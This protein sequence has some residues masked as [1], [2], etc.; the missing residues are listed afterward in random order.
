MNRYLI[1]SQALATAGDLLWARPMSATSALGI[2][3]RSLAALNERCARG[4]PS[5]C[6]SAR[7]LGNIAATI[8]TRK[9]DP[10]PNQAADILARAAE[11]ATNQRVVGEE[12]AAA[13]TSSAQPFQEEGG[14]EFADSLLSD[15][16]YE[17]Q[18]RHEVVDEG[19]DYSGDE[20]DEFEAIKPGNE[21]QDTYGGGEY[22][23]GVAVLEWDNH[24]TYHP[25]E[26]VY[27]GQKHW[28]ALRQ[29]DP[30]ALPTFM[31]GDVPGKSDAWR[32]VSP[33]EV[34][35]GNVAGDVLGMFDIGSAQLRMNAL[36]PVTV[37]IAKSL[38]HG[39]QQVMAVANTTAAQHG[40][41]GQTARDGVVGH[42]Q[43]HANKLAGLKNGQA[44]YASGDDVKLYAMRAWIEANAVEEG[45]AYLDEA[46]T[47]MWAEIG[48]ELAALP[49]EI[50]QAARNLPGQIFE[51]ATGIP[52]WAF[53]LGAAVIVGG[54]VYG[55]FKILSGPAG[56]AVVGHYLRRR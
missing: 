30:P 51:G 56:G 35:A 37:G 50:L 28:R 13:A 36:K 10:L 40:L 24:N 39:G 46:W 38:V 48:A 34:Y 43:W 55:I 16:G 18:A 12:E 54:L 42:L 14:D 8:H 44:L 45:A 29:V 15:F 21:E 26:I 6:E 11:D 33:A 1:G 2:V 27:C 5:A 23:V 47:A 41:P 9:I 32:E 19:N 3:T 20:E 49:K 17:T 22:V 7:V 53:W 25:G 4:V 31:D 52:P